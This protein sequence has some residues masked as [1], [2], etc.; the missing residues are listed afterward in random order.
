MRLPTCALVATLAAATACSN[1]AAPAPDASRPDAAP[2]DADP[3]APDADVPL[4]RLGLLVINEVGAS[5]TPDWVEVVNAT[6]SPLAL[7]D[8]LFVDVAGDF[9]KARPFPTLTLA[10]G[11]RHVQDISDELVGFKL[12]SDEAVYLYR[13]TDRALS[14]YADWA[15]GE[16]PAGGSWARVPDTSGEFQTL[17]TATRGQPN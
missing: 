12:G 13:A 9:V 3:L 15:E 7:G 10:P 16:S 5:D 1:S 17:D 8:Y 14:D 2:P 6:L 4:P 11:Q